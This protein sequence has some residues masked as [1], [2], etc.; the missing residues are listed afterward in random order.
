MPGT[1][2]ES[3]T[4]LGK[5]PF[6]LST[7][8][9]AKNKWPCEMP[10]K[11]YKDAWQQS[12]RESGREDR[13][14]G[15]YN[16]PLAAPITRCMCACRLDVYLNMSRD[17][18]QAGIPRQKETP[19]GRV[20][21]V[22]RNQGCVGSAHSQRA[23]NRTLEERHITRDTTERARHRV[24]TIPGKRVVQTTYKDDEKNGAL[25]GEKCRNVREQWS[26]IQNMRA[27]KPQASFRNKCRVSGQL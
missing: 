3:L 14:K 24:T 18:S 9:Y 15:C 22:T 5:M 23:I 13:E 16:A 19:V 21:V 11:L 20:V 7:Q 4:L 27:T 2:T 12:N 6:N 8:M 26:K 1:L 25:P 10:A 17:S